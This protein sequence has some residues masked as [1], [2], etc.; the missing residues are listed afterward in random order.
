MFYYLVVT[1]SQTI[2]HINCVLCVLLQE[3]LTIK[4]NILEE[5]VETFKRMKNKYSNT[6]DFMK[7]L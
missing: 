2:M 7:V 3:E 6:V 1:R 5:K 4:V